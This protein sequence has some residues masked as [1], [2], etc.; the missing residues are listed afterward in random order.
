MHSLAT[1]QSLL[2]AQ[3]GI[4]GFTT[5]SNSY[6]LCRIGSVKTR[7][8]PRR[9]VISVGQIN[10]GGVFRRFAPPR[11]GLRKPAEHAANQKLSG[12][13]PVQNVD[14]QPG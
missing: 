14:Y 10:R 5:M 11:T 3:G 7:T 12:I 13:V 2:G 6:K 8:V 1:F 4:G 9:Q